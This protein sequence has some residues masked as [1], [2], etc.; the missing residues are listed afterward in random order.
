MMRILYYHLQYMSEFINITVSYI[1]FEYLNIF[2]YIKLYTP[3]VERK[4]NAG[5]SAS[6]NINN[7]IN[8]NNNNNGVKIFLYIHLIF[9]QL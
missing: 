4:D 8:I 7:D 3:V 2:K 9:N 1:N 5:I 6:S